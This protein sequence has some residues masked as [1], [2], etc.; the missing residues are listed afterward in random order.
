M[1]VPHH[2]GAVAMGETAQVRAEHPE[3]TQMAEAILSTQ[4]RGFGQMSRDAR[5]VISRDR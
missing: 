5:K 4:T 3:I 2:E 1:M